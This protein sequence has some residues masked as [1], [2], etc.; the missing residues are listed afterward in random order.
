[1]HQVTAIL[2]DGGLVVKDTP[3]CMAV[4][5]IEVPSTEIPELRSGGHYI[6]PWVAEIW[7]LQ[8]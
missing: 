2:H 5:P 7:R 1:M 6:C 3:C 4:H 8:V